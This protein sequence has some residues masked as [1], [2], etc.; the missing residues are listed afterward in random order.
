M[1]DASPI[2]VMTAENLPHL[3]LIHSRNDDLIP[4]INSIE[5]YQKYSAL[6]ASG[7]EFWQTEHEG[8]ATGYMVDRDKYLEKYFLSSKGFTRAEEFSGLS[9]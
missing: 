1:T 4:V 9:G 5:L 6:N 7:A 3:M 2:D 8:H